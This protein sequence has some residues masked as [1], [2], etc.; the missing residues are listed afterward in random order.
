MNPHFNTE[1]V[2]KAPSISGGRWLAPLRLLASVAGGPGLLLL[3]LRLLLSPRFPPPF[4]PRPRLCK[5][6]FGFAPTCSIAC[7]LR[8]PPPL[9]TDPSFL[10]RPPL[11]SSPLGGGASIYHPAESGFS[12]RPLQSL[13]GR[14]GASLGSKRAL[15]PHPPLPTAQPLVSN[16]ESCLTFSS[17]ARTSGG[18]EGKKTGGSRRQR[19][20]CP[21]ETKADR[22]GGAE[23]NRALLEG[24][25]SKIGGGGG[26]ERPPPSS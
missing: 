11:L 21:G 8:P 19:G 17:A 22:D 14:R 9:W 12:P 25:Q 20:V 2:M 23:G 7:S 15:G 5:I 18:E 4:N 26:I 16:L 6:S 13:H 1:E 10:P 24:R 3:L